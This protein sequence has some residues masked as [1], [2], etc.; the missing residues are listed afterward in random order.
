MAT[1]Q[2]RS[3]DDRLYHALSV[4]ATMENRSISQEVITI[5]EDYLSRPSNRHKSITEEFLQLCGTWRDERSESEIA[6][7]IRRERNSTGGRFE[8]SL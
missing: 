7:E 2:V 5:L 4:R 8:G 1:L 6:A 3:V